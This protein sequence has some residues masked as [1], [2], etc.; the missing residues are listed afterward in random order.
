[1]TNPND[2]AFASPKREGFESLIN[3]LGLTKREYFAALAMSGM[4]A[5]SQRIGRNDEYAK[6]A[7]NAADALIAEM[8]K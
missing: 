6:T 7:V 4:L 3:T 1:M 8:N 5:N 2:P